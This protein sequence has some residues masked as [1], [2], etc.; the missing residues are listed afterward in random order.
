MATL[1]AGTESAVRM[2]T[3]NIGTWLTGTVDDS[4]PT[5][6]K[7]GGPGDSYRIFGGTGFTYSPTGRFNGGT[8]QSVY[9]SDGSGGEPWGITGMSM[10]V[11]TFNAYASA[12]NTAAF[13]AA[14]FAGNDTLNGHS[15]HVFDDYLNGYGGHDKINGGAGNDTLIGGAGNDS[16]VGGSNSYY[17]ELD[18]GT[19]ADTMRG[20]GGFDKYFVDNTGD[21]VVEASGAAGGEDG[22]V[23][24]ISYTLAENVEHLELLDVATAKNAGGNALDNSIGGNVFANKLFG[25]AGDDQIFGGDGNDTL[26]GG[27]NADDMTGGSGNDTYY[28]DSSSDWVNETSGSGIDLV[29]ASTDF[30]LYAALGQVENLTLAGTGNLTGW[31]NGLDNTIT[32][33]T[34]TNNL[35]GYSGNDTISGGGGSDYLNGGLGSD[36]LNGGLGNDT[37]DGGHGTNVINVFDGN[38]TVRHQ[39]SVDA[40]DIIQNFDGNPTGGQDVLDLDSMFDALGVAAPSRA[41]RVQLTDKGSSV[42]VR[43]DTDNNGTFDYL[44]ATVQSA[45]TI[46]VGS[47]VLVG[48]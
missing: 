34:G 43:I 9:I 13:L 4:W 39:A 47:D 8:L 30:S 44:A 46:T 17:D 42:D 24:S 32:G 41:G 40:L 35:Y 28:V 45:N 18:G 23:S 48:T 37:V 7:V 5:H 3:M 27:A 20:E 38:D 25:L 33:N 22:V 26:D 11:A 31:G 16:L 15:W 19:G 10:P 36:T 2:D 6:M 12:G 1:Y 14:V 21:V 29:I